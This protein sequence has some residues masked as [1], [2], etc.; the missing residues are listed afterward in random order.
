MA[1]KGISPQLYLKI[2]LICDKSMDIQFFELI[3]G[4]SGWSLLLRPT[5]WLA[6]RTIMRAENASPA[7]VN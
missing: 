7:A 6:S 3:S 4:L 1:T 5:N 2:C